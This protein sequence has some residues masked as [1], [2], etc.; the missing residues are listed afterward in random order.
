MAGFLTVFS[1]ELSVFVLMVITMERWYAISYAI[2]LT[3][4]L[5]IRQAWGLMVTGW[6]YASTMA[7]LPL[8]GVS[9]YG[10]VSICLPME[11]K[12]VWDKLYIIALLVLNGLAFLVICCCYI[13]MFMKVGGGGD[14]L[15][16]KGPHPLSGTF[17]RQ[18]DRT[19]SCR[20]S[21]QALTS[22]SDSVLC[23]MWE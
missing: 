5:R 11:A 15:S 9:G 16:L 3:K 10:A 1:S 17:A 6:L 4:R 7:L 21:R 22:P 18:W 13:S 14:A 23:L 8:V 19:D 20:G 12:D 2:H